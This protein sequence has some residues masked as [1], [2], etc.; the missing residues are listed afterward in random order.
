MN[1]TIA[2]LVEKNGV[3]A[4]TLK[5]NPPRRPLHCLWTG[6]KKLSPVRAAQARA[7]V[8]LLAPVLK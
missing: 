2:I 8:R 6:W 1:Q 5:R 3:F 4:A 7:L